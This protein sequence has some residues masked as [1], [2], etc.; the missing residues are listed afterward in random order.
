MFFQI[1]NIRN[2]AHKVLAETKVFSEKYIQRGVMVLQ[3]IHPETWFT[4]KLLFLSSHLF[5]LPLLYHLFNP[6]VRLKT[7]IFSAL[8]AN[9]VFSIA[10]WSNPIRWGNI[11]RIDAAAARISIIFLTFYVLVFGN[12][13]VAGMWWF[14]LIIVMLFIFFYLSNVFSSYEWCCKEHILC[15]FMAH[16]FACLSITFT[17][18]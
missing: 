11:H 7:L 8:F 2:S 18:G 6:N 15:H 12:L 17:Y 5:I 16:I 1:N 10:F 9:F 14:I 4:H 13:S 3:R